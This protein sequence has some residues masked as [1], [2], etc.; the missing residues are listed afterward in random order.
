S[1]EQTPSIPLPRRVR[2]ENEEAEQR[3]FLENL[4]QLHINFPFIEDLAQMPKYAKFLKGLLTNKVRL[5]E[6]SEDDECYGIDDLDDTINAE[7]Q[8]LLTNDRSN[9]FLLKG[10]EKSN[11][12]D[13]ESCESLENKS[14]NESDLGMPI[15]RINLLNTPYSVEQRK[16]RSDEVKSEHL[17]SASATEI[18]EKRLELKSLLS[19]LEYA[20][21]QGD[22]SFPIIISSKLSEKEKK[23]L[24]QVLENR[25]VAFAWKMLDI[26]GISLSFCM[27]KI[28]MKDDFKPVIPQM[29]LNPKVQYVVKNKIVKLLDSRLIYRISDSLWISLFHVVPKKGGMTV[30]LNDNNELIPSRTVTRWRAELSDDEPWMNHMRSDYA[31]TMLRGDVLL[32]AKSLKSWSG[33]ISSRSKMHQNNIQVEAQALLTNDARIVIKFLRK[34]FARFGVPKAL[35]TIK[36]IL[37][38]SVGY[39]PKNWSEKLDDALWAFR[40]AYKTPTRCTPFRLVYGKACHLPMEIEHKAYWALKQCNMDLTA[41][42]KN[43]FMEH[44]ELMELKDEAY[45]NTRIYKERTKKW[46]DSRLREDKNFK[47]GDKVLLLNSRFKMHPGKLK[48]KWYR[49]NVVKTVYPYTTVEITDKN[50]ISFKVNGQRLKKYYDGNVNADER[51]VFEFKENTT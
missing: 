12:S 38:R 8:E 28:L 41:A 42:T 30:V 23:L 43:R 32:E 4:K 36:R 35:I 16:A 18:D 34:L 3:K 9:S 14:N 10:L 6:A 15:R 13:I 2:K 45:E 46:H 25:K 11:Q 27:H 37:K 39:N 22:K 47:V 5:E 48:S 26:K 31:K 19:H 7:A 49:P 21:L 24:L 44:N 40:T 33:N 1:E 51:E 29:C 17:Y 20:F 50:E